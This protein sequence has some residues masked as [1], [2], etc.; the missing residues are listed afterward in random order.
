[1]S[2]TLRCSSLTL[3]LSYGEN[4]PSKHYQRKLCD[5][6]GKTE[7]EPGFPEQE[8]AREARKHARP[9]PT[10]EEA[11]PV[12]ESSETTREE[13]RLAQ[14]AEQESHAEHL[15]VS[16]V[17]LCLEESSSPK[18]EQEQARSSLADTHVPAYASLNS[19]IHPQGISNPP[20][21]AHSGQQDQR[22]PTNN[23]E[24]TKRRRSWSFV[25]CF[26]LLTVMGILFLLQTMM[27]QHW[28]FFTTPP[29]RRLYY[30]HAH[31][32]RRMMSPFIQWME[33]SV[34]QAVNQCPS[35]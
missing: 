28:W 16:L 18:G 11:K 25:L 14:R 2:K 26:L 7:E 35:I 12:A 8:Q 19:P 24:E 1:M 32:K 6:F 27:T 13:K 31:L 22:L 17:T 21:S 4:V 30:I 23:G 9:E 29:K 20:V 33:T 15:N 5:L 10:S 34:F 3:A